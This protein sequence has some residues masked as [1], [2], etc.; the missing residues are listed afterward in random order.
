ME[1]LAIKKVFRGENF[2]VFKLVVRTR[3]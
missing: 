2:H 1:N 3:Q